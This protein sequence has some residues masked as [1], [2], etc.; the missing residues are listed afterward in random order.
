MSPRHASH[1]QHRPYDNAYDAFNNY[2]NVLSD[3]ISRVHEEF[4][5]GVENEE[6]N[7]LLTLIQNQENEIKKLEKKLAKEKAKSPAPV[8]ATK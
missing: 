5:E 7:S 4:P 6:L 3:F 2:M 8:K 1:Q